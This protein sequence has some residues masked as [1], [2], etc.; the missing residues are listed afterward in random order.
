MVSRLEQVKDFSVVSFWY[1]ALSIANQSYRMRMVP[2]EAVSIDEVGRFAA[3]IFL[4]K[5]IRERLRQG[6]IVIVADNERVIGIRSTHPGSVETV[7]IVRFG[8]QRGAG[9]KV[10][11]RPRFSILFS[12]Q[13]DFSITINSVKFSSRAANVIVAT[14]GVGEREIRL[15]EPLFMNGR[16]KC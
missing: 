2:F 13:G 7:D 15:G 1:E 12:P 11:T 14:R 16:V 10:L 4:K 6:H 3:S 9:S 5:H 8:P